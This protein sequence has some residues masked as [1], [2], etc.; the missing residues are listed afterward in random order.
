MVCFLIIPFFHLIHSLHK[1]FLILGIIKVV[2]NYKCVEW[3]LILKEQIYWVIWSVKVVISWVWWRFIIPLMIKWLWLR[4]HWKPLYFVCDLFSIFNT[5]YLHL[6][7]RWALRYL[8]LAREA[9]TIWRQVFKMVFLVEDDRRLLF[10]SKIFLLD[11]LT[12]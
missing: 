12:L 7:I 6:K 10:L 4:K 1:P 2:Y 3:I 11:D 8:T 9:F 5:R